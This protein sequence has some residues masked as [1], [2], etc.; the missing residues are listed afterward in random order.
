M[1]TQERKIITKERKWGRKVRR[2]GR[3]TDKQTDKQTNRKTD[4]YRKITKRN[5]PCLP[6]KE[7]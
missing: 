4:K 5:W 2:A 3:Q 7:K 6:K 1:P